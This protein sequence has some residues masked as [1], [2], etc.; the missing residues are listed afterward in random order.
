MEPAHGP[1]SYTKHFTVQGAAMRPRK[2]F[3]LTV[4][5]VACVPVSTGADARPRFPGI[6]G[7]VAGTI[8]G[9]VGLRHRQALARPRYQVH[10]ASQRAPERH[11]AVE[12]PRSPQPAASGNGETGW[13]R[14]VFWPRLYDD[15]FDAVL[16]PTGTDDRIWA[17]GYG[18]IVEGMFPPGN[19]YADAGATLRRRSPQTT[20][21]VSDDNRDAS[22]DQLCTSKHGAGAVDALIERIGQTVQPTEAQQQ[23]LEALRPAF[24]RAFEY[25]HAACPAGRSSGPT[26]RLDSMDDRLWAAR[27]ALL[28]TRAPIESFYGT[29]TDEQKTRL[30][31]ALPQAEQRTAPC[32]G[33]GADLPS[34]QIERRVRPNQQQRAGWEALRMT[35]LGMAKFLQAS[36]PAATPAT[37]IERLDAADKR[38]NALLYAVVNLRAPLDAFYGSLGNEQRTR[39]NTV[40]R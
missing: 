34:A 20:G 32:G 29:L 18:D 1:V 31:G 25:I 37:P 8:G 21:S 6:F 17:Y 27:Q 10:R 12:Q 22:A 39:F 40:S 7:A 13:V 38:L 16:W 26:A 36:C 33:Q 19:A 11:A 28:V 15:L 4:A 30:N 23:S 24:Q 9:I 5:I 2:L 3:L 35:S 14:A